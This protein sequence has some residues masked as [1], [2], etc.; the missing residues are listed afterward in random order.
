M[1]WNPRTALDGRKFLF[2]F[3]GHSLAE[4]KDSGPASRNYIPINS[5][6]GK[7]NESVANRGNVYRKL[8]TAWYLT[9]YMEIT[10]Y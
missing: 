8:K 4:E 7:F 6:D 1:I 5:F 2:F 9:I 3:A 10:T